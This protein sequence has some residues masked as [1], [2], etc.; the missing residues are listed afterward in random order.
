MF[1]SMLYG[2]DPVSDL[3]LHVLRALRSALWVV[4]CGS[5]VTPVPPTRPRA[6]RS[7]L[8]TWASQGQELSTELIARTPLILRISPSYFTNSR[9]AYVLLCA[10]WRRPSLRSL[11]TCAI[12][13]ALYVMDGRLRF[14]SHACSSYTCTGSALDVI[15]YGLAKAMGVSSEPTVWMLLILRIIA[16]WLKLRRFFRRNT[17]KLH[18]HAPYNIYHIHKC[19]L[20][21]RAF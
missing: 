12:G 8:W 10:L 11:P 4:D 13:S 6:P 1:R 18:T 9:A 7:T 19:F 21:F 17:S 16:L 3:S 14:L 15:D 2:E 20:H 5:L